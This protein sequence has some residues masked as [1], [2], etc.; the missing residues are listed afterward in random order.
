M[1]LNGV[2]GND[3]R[4][5][6]SCNNISHAEEVAAFKRGQGLRVRINDRGLTQGLRIY[7]ITVSW[8]VG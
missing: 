3:V 5:K 8:W 7:P 6:V 2:I 4:G 1:I